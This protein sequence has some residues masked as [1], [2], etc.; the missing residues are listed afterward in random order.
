MRRRVAIAAALLLAFPAGGVAR[1]NQQPLFEFGRVGGNIEPYTVQIKT[2]GTLGS[3][4]DVKLAKPRTRLSQARLAALLR[5][6][7]TQHFWSLAPRTFCRGS[8]P[9]FASTYVTIHSAGKTRTVSVR[10]GCR[11]RLTHLFRALSA[12]GTVTS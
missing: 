9:D 7:R 8:L 3:S 1:A 6:A 10:G 11:P 4:G 12:A 2:D 5:Y